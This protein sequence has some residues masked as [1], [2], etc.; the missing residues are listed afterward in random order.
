MRRRIWPQIQGEV[1]T[2]GNNPAAGARAPPERSGET[3]HPSSARAVPPPRWT[4]MSVALCPP[5]SRGRAGTGEPPRGAV[6]L[7]AQAAA[8]G[9]SPGSRAAPSAGRGRCSNCVTLPR[10]CLG[11]VR[12]PSASGQAPRWQ[13][14][15]CLCPGTRRCLPKTPSLPPSSP[16]A[17]PPMLLRR[18]CGPG[19]GKGG[20]AGGGQALVLGVDEAPT[21]GAWPGTRRR[22]GHGGGFGVAGS[23]VPACV[24]LG[25][26]SPSKPPFPTCPAA[27]KR[28]P[29][30]S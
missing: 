30:P 13:G 2:P 3:S 8:R 23:V 20:K 18:L 27:T 25:S 11:M 19:L 29:V 9:G 28:P 6:P 1:S 26:S 15:R 4:G 21:P 12:S 14:P 5:R 17:F 16:P 10:S 22:A 7:A 24:T